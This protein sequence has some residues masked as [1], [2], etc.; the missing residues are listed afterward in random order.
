MAPRTLQLRPAALV[1]RKS[2]STSVTATLKNDTTSCRTRHSSYLSVLLEHD[3]LAIAVDQILVM[4]RHCNVDLAHQIKQP[5]KKRF[6][7]R[8]STKTHAPTHIP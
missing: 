7:N 5:C 3:G 2:S 6:F 8:F 1:L 4:Q